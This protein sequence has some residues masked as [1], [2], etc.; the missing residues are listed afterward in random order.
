[1]HYK[2]KST[3]LKI[4][5]GELEATEGL[6]SR[7]PRL[8]MGRFSQHHVDQLDLNLTALESFQKVCGTTSMHPD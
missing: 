1:M 4:I 6:C 2:G 5:L 7:A 8:R 3:L